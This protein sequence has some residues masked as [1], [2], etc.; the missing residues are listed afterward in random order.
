MKLEWFKDPIEFVISRW[1][2]AGSKG[3][4]DYTCKDGRWAIHL[5]V[6]Y[7]Y[8]CKITALEFIRRHYPVIA[9]RIRVIIRKEEAHAAK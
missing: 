7:E 2:I 4:L 1:K 9:D 6:S 3:P 8:H 5:D